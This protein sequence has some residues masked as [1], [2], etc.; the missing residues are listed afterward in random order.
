MED[1][2]EI[3][4]QKEDKSE[5]KKQKKKLNDTQKTWILAAV[6]ILACILVS[7]CQSLWKSYNRTKSAEN[8]STYAYVDY[9][10]DSSGD[11]YVSD[12]YTDTYMLDELYGS[13]VIEFGAGREKALSDFIAKYYST[14]NIYTTDKIEP[15]KTVTFYFRTPS[16]YD[17]Q[18]HVW[19]NCEPFQD[20]VP[21]R[22]P[23][24]YD[25]S[26]SD[27]DSASDDIQ[28]SSSYGSGYGS[29][30]SYGNYRSNSSSGQSKKNST[31]DYEDEDYADDKEYWG[32]DYD[33]EDYEDDNFEYDD[34]DDTYY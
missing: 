20:D 17:R 7:F 12:F 23:E 30:S 24:S 21:V 29:S 1:K 22:W 31:S 25:S 34:Y 6:L 18:F 26:S 10:E 2:Q 14:S 19:V 5:T 3:N 13:T 27:Q 28:N 33:E 15:G 11:Y 16:G 32:D 9:E 8:L 4:H